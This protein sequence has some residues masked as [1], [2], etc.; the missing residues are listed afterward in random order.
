MDAVGIAGTVLFLPCLV[1]FALTALVGGGIGTIFTRNAKKSRIIPLAILLVGVGLTIYIVINYIPHEFWFSL[2]PS[3]QLGDEKL[4]PYESAITDFDRVSLG[5]TA[6]PRDANIKIIDSDEEYYV[7][8]PDVELYIPDLPIKRQHICLKKVGDQY[9]WDSEYE[10][11]L[12]PHPWESIWLAYSSHPNV[13]H[14]YGVE[15]YTFIIAY[16]GSSDPRLENRNL[17]F[18][19]IQPILDEW[20]SYHEAQSK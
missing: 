17:T 8:C 13:F 2:Y 12:G 15:P 19:Y 5:F 6:I 10:V 1:L 9:V 20:N 7:S 4:K 16:S 18:E 11:Y 3:Y 14:T